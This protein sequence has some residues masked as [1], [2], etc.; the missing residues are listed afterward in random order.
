[1]ATK[2][3][4]V[5]RS[6]RGAVTRKSSKKKTVRHSATKKTRAKS[7]SFLKAPPGTVIVGA[8]TT[9]SPYALRALSVFSEGVQRALSQLARRNITAVVI[10]NGKRVEAVPTKIDGRYV[11]IESQVLDS[12]GRTTSARKRGLRTG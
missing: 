1:M 8:K 4:R 7:A 3:V 12:T 5:K 11:V 6:R 10:E 9:F 2:K